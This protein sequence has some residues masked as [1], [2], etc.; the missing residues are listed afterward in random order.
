M[1]DIKHFVSLRESL[2]RE[3][4]Q[5]E[6][7]LQAINDALGHVSTPSLS[8]VSGAK[9]PSAPS[10]S[11]GGRSAEWRARIAAAQRARWAE[12]RKGQDSSPA[13]SRKAAGGG[14]RVMSPEAREKIAAAA[15]RRWAAARRAGKNKL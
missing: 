6:Q 12:R 3:K 1:Q 13:M 7:R 8:S 10:T 15:R 2:L 9:A 14:K 5:I 11:A 4:E